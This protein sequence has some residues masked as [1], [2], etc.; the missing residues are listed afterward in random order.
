M[1]T[2]TGPDRHRPTLAWAELEDDVAPHLRATLAG[3]PGLRR[4]PPH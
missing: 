1:I 4:R 2:A 3:R